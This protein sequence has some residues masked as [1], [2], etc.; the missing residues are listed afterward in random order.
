[1]LKFAIQAPH[2]TQSRQEFDFD[3]G[4]AHE[5]IPVKLKTYAEGRTPLGPNPR[6]RMCRYNQVRQVT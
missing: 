1:M 6:I 3:F 4:N 5:Y 2:F